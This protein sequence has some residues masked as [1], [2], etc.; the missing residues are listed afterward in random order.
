MAN[1]FDAAGKP[2]HTPKDLRDTFASQLIT[3]GIQLP[4]VSLQLG[5]ADQ[6]LTA[7]HYAKW[8]ALEGYRAPIELGDGQVPADLLATICELDSV[9]KRHEIADES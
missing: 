3:A 1:L 9:E 8:V 4:Y 2:R 5:H 7:R 6:A